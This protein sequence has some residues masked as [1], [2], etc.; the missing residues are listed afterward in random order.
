MIT[1]RKPSFDFSRSKPHWAPEWEFA[2]MF[3]AQSMLFPPLERYLNRVMALARTKIKGDAPEDVALRDDIG[4]FIQ[5]EGQHYTIH[6]AYNTMLEKAGFSKLPEFERQMD[7]EYRV[8][9]KDKSLKFLTAYCDGFETL[10]PIFARVYLDELEDYFAGADPEIVAMWKWHLLEEFEHRNVCFDVYERIHGGYFYRIYGMIWAHRHMG[11]YI[12]RVT[13]Y[14]FEQEY[15]T[16]TEEEIAASKQ[17]LRR[18]RKRMGKFALPGLLKLLLPTYS[19]HK[20]RV[21]D[22]YDSF[23]RELDRRFALAA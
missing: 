22:G 11:G 5:Q 16:M 8:L 12:K 21:P 23:V 13:E 15:E 14:M 2:T 1:I 17:R 20:A 6:T 18:F 7:E 10:G 3:N 19:P 9:L 4:K